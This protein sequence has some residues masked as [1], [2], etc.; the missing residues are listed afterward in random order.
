MKTAYKG[1]AGGMTT[2]PRGFAFVRTARFTYKASATAPQQTMYGNYCADLFGWLQDAGW[3]FYNDTQY[4]TGGNYYNQGSAKA[5]GYNQGGVCGYIYTVNVYTISTSAG[6]G[7]TMSGGGDFESGQTA[8]VK[9]TPSSGY[10]VDTLNG[11][12]QNGASGVKSVT[13]TVTADQT[14]SATFKPYYKLAF[15]ANGG[16][17]A[18]GSLT[19]CFAN[20]AYA[21]P[22]GAPTWA[23]HQFVGW[24]TST[25]NA[26]NGVVE[27][28]PG[29][30]YVRQSCTANQTVTLYAAWRQYTLS[31]DANGG[32]PVPSSSVSYGSVTLA[33]APSRTGRTFLGWKIGDAVYGAGAT[34]SLTSD[35]TAVAQ[36]TNISF[37]NDDPSI[38]TL[39]LFDVSL[40]RKVADE[41]GGY[42]RHSGVRNHVYRVD[43]SV[44]NA[45]YEGRGVY[46]DGAY[47]DPYQFTMGADDVTGTFHYAKKPLYSFTVASAHGTVTATPSPDEDGKYVRGRAIT[48]SIVPDAG[49][50]AVQAAFV[51]VDTNDVSNKSVVSNAVTLDGIVFNTRAVIDYSPIDYALAAA[52][53][54]AS[55]S[56]VT[57][58][59]VTV[60]GTAA[61][62]AHYGDKATFS[63]TVAS[64]YGFA[65]W[66]DAGGALVSS[67]AEYEA[68]VAGG[69]SL[70]A[71][72]EVAV[73]LGISYSGTGAQN[74]ALTVGGSAYTPGTEFAVVLG[75]S[76]AYALSLGERVA[77]TPWQFDCWKSGDATLAYDKTGEVTPTAAFTMTAHVADA[78]SRTLEILV[79]NMGASSGVAVD[80][81]AVPSAVTCHGEADEA[82]DGSG[83][84]GEADPFRFTFARTQVVHFTAAE[85]LTFAGEE[86]AKTFY[87]FSTAEPGTGETALPPEGSVLSFE[88]S[89]ELLL[90]TDTRRVYAY[91]GT[92]SVVTTTLAYA[93]LSD[94]TMGVVAVVAT[95]PTDSVED[96]IA[97]DGKSARAT[98][99]KS[100]TIRATPKNGYRFAG[101]HLAAGAVGD[102]R[103]SDAEQTVTATVQRTIYAKFAKNTHSVCEWEGGSAPK[104]LVWRSKTYEASKPFNP[105]SCRVDALGYAGDGRGTLLVLTVDMFFAPDSAATSTATLANIASQDA[106]RLP[107][108]RMER[109]M[110]IEVKADAEVD[111][112]LVGTSMGGLAQ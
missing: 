13:I 66:Y 49:Y 60:G 64:G 35:V 37:Q 32:S 102:A 1:S 11:V 73:S 91:Y 85:S 92:P 80:A 38:G 21:I 24:A 82:S 45:L 46:V 34:Y 53:H 29:G 20:V 23:G 50:S 94:S 48:L 31:Y 93:D 54:P 86:A 62:S 14:V 65:G 36:W 88:A 47:V 39:S 83:G 15:D 55:A 68:T 109:Y 97:A 3:G 19:R 99:G 52:K 26:T 74:C 111:A 4:S 96:P 42:L 79:V 2:D 72:A 90:N 8:T 7:G 76:F 105:S 87:C 69:L 104:A 89:S 100:I 16:T 112:L 61:D 40:N 71:K 58:V 98:Q 81:D 5:V 51:N 106:R 63:A 18:P 22:D 107:V 28:Q 27:C 78:V 6:T 57:S 17:N 103:W 70:F 9:A 10:V 101:W 56:A 67:D 30:T 41:S 77:D 43:C 95:D 59:S 84:D 25:G 108:R 75:E 44:S 33:A 12:S 110:Q